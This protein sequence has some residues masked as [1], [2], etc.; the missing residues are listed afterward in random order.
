MATMAIQAIGAANGWNWVFMAAG[1]LLGNYL[2]SKWFGTNVQGDRLSALTI[3]SSSAG[4][5]IPKCYGSIRCETNLIWGTHFVEHANKQRSGG[6][7]GGSTYTSYTYSCSFAVAICR[8]PISGIGRVWADGNLI[9]ISQ[10]DYSLYLG[11]ETQMPDPYIE[12]KQGAGNVPAHR[13]LAYIVFKNMSITTYGNRVPSLAIEVFTP[14]TK[15]SDIV[16]DVCMEHGID[17]AQLVVSDLESVSLLGFK[18]DTSQTGREKLQNLQNYFI[19]DG[20]ENDGVLEFI[21][22]SNFSNVYA[23]PY[24]DLGA[25]ESTPSDEPYNFNNPSD[26]DMPRSVTLNFLSYENDYQ[27]GSITAKRRNVISTDDITVTANFAL[28][29]ADAKA[30]VDTLLYAQWI[31]GRSFSATLSSKWAHLKP[32]DKIEVT[33]SSGLKV[34]FLLKKVTFGDPGLVKVE[35]VVVT[36][37]MYTIAPKYADSTNSAQTVTVPTDV[38]AEIMDLPKLPGDTKTTDD[39]TVYIATTGDI[40][41]GANVFQS[42]DNGNEYDLVVY[43]NPKAVM[44]TVAEQ[45]AQESAQLFDHTTSIN[46]TLIAGTLASIEQLNFLQNANLALIGNEIV[47][48]K[49]ALLVSGNTY[50]LTEFIRGM[51]GT[52]SA[53]SQHLAGERFVLLAEGTLGGITLP[54]ASWH[55]SYSY[56]IGPKTQVETADTYVKKDFTGQGVMSKCLAPCHAKAVRDSG[57]LNVSWIRRT[58]TGGE[59]NDYV[60]ASLGEATEAYSIDVYRNGTA[61]RTVAVTTP[62]L[63]YTQAQQIADFGSVQSAVRFVIYQMNETRGRGYGKD[64]TL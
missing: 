49:N 17:A 23:V 42:K 41:V 63:L 1:A 32:G 8:G 4:V 36:A 54:A 60:D 56:L 16:A 53:I 44:G 20:R 19:F 2:D 22:R 52:E 24:E 35:C 48:F 18:T 27:Q 64:V 33:F 39:N 3:Q 34:L 62:S 21:K 6:K 47:S 55:T 61:V 26:Y 15:L 50:K 12:A 30:V 51:F 40:Y 7:G 10:Y 25:F 29:D 59:W 31:S 58:R 28:H 43:N 9:D 57:D 11:D 14:V 38:T 5:A 13:G 46:V 45:M 37:D